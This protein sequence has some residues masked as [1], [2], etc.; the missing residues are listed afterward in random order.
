MIVNLFIKFNNLELVK[1][2]KGITKLLNARSYN[3][4]ETTFTM[5]GVLKDGS[6]YDMNEFINRG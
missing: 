1:D 6:Y 5:L 2:T 3:G 4:E